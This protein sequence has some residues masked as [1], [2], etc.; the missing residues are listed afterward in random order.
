MSFHREYSVPEN[1]AFCSKII[2]IQTSRQGPKNVSSCINTSSKYGPPGASSVQSARSGHP[3][4]PPLP[5][6]DSA[7]PPLHS[8]A[9]ESSR[10][11]AAKN[12]ADCSAS[13]RP[14]RSYIPPPMVL[15]S[16]QPVL[17]P[18]DR[19]HHCTRKILQKQKPPQSG[20]EYITHPWLQEFDFRKC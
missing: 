3:G 19:Q 15:Y 4:H 7:V 16:P 8:G 10:W 12:T 17:F 20:R 1:A 5:R 2:K 11:K 6:P 9:W 18:L 13:A 14:L